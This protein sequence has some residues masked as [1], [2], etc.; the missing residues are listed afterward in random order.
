MAGIADRCGVSTEQREAILVILYCS[1]CHAPASDAVT[2]LALR[3]ELTSV[4][5][6]VAISALLPGFGKNFRDVAR[7]TEDVLMHATKREPRFA[8]VIEL[9]LSSQR[10]PARDCVA[11]VAGDREGAVRIARR[12]RVRR[13]KRENDCNRKPLEIAELSQP[14][15]PRFD[16]SPPSPPY[17]VQS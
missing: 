8:V 15:F 2:V 13:R 9:Y 6:R 14:V 5:I 11:I 16:T 12:L 1:R 4:E 17:G 3:T 10:R 7:I